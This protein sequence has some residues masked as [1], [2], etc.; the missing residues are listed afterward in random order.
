MISVII[1]ILLLLYTLQN[2]EAMTLSF[3]LWSFSASK[4]LI[5]LV[6]FAAGIVLGFFIGKIGKRKK[7]ETNAEGSRCQSLP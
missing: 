3:A 2:T 1:L 7:K 5:T 6:I 4:A